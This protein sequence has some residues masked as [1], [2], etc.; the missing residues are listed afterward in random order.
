[1]EK[2]KEDLVKALNGATKIKETIDKGKKGQKDEEYQSVEARFEAQ[3]KKGQQT[4]AAYIEKDN[5]LMK[6]C[7]G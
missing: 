3:L 2:C 6:Q 1:M 4:E 7:Y 5:P